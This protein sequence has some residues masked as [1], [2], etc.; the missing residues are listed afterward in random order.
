MS[1]PYCLPGIAA[2]RPG[3][4]AA[5]IL[6]A[7]AEAGGGSSA[8]WTRLPRP[9]RQREGGDWG[10]S[11]PIH[12]LRAANTELSRSSLV[13]WRLKDLALSLLW[14]RSLL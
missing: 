13:A 14:L 9:R 12:P 6:R 2:S 7:P 3:T 1:H 8:A 5:V 11:D 4:G 10:R